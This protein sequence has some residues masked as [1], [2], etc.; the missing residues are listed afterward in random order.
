MVDAY[1]VS[2]LQ[3]ALGLSD[4]QFVKLL[5]LVKRLQT[6]RRAMFQRRQQALR[7]MRDLLQ[8]GT[9]KEGRV[10][11]LLKEVRGVEA[12]EPAAIRR[13]LEAIDAALSPLQQAKYLI[14]EI[15]V[16][17]KIRE[18]MNQIRV[19]G[20][21]GARTALGEPRRPPRW[22][23]PAM[24][25]SG[26]PA[27]ASLDEVLPLRRRCPYTRGDGEDERRRATPEGS[28]TGC[29]TAGS[30]AREAS[31]EAEPPRLPLPRRRLRV[32]G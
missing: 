13:D 14:L 18:L 5:P 20:V 23:R 9:A 28:G 26:A 31:P 4:E 27:A 7:E 1:I 22:S 12:E 10:L 21:P 15:E 29:G 6:D 2:N 3:E 8:T 30:R 32:A 17:Q 25:P 19:K 16:E 24:P 11:E